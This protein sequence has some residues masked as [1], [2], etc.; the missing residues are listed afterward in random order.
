[1][2]IGDPAKTGTTPAFPE[3]LKRTESIVEHAFNSKL[4]SLITHDLLDITG[5]IPRGRF[6]KHSVLNPVVYVVRFPLTPGV[7]SNPKQ[8]TFVVQFEAAGQDP[9]GALS[10]TH[11]IVDGPAAITFTT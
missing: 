9:C 3:L 8:M 6:P 11:C 4:L 1:M 10:G 5:V 2:I 7:Y